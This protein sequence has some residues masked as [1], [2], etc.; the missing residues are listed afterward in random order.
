[1]KRLALV[2][3]TV[4]IVFMIASCSDGGTKS[5]VQSDY[6]KDQ[7]PPVE[8]SIT[9]SAKGVYGRSAA[10]D[11]RFKPGRAPMST[12]GKYVDLKLNKVLAYCQTVRKY[13]AYWNYTQSTATLSQWLN[14][15]CTSEYG[16]ATTIID[17]NEQQCSSGSGTYNNA[18]VGYVN[19]HSDL[20]TAYNTSAGGQSKSL[21]GK[22]HY[23]AFGRGEG[24]TYA[25]LS[26]A[27]CG[28]TTTT[29][30]STTSNSTFEGYVNKYSDL[31][32]AWLWSPVVSKSA[33]GKSHYCA[34]GRY[35]G[36][37]YPGLS[38]ASCGSTTTTTTTTSTSTSSSSSRRV[39]DR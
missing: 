33:W 22:N 39:V 38:S 28:S 25:G 17:K 26:S 5:G 10:C 37:T 4:A 31:W 34:Y 29:S 20:V 8:G 13:Y 24:R 30:T 18:A 16:S 7:V 6:A 27:T 1:M 12:G 19:K 35:E 11:Y 23:C 3:S 15:W 9:S 36:R 21:W 2:I 32:V 14:D